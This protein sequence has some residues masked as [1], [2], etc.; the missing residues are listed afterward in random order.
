MHSFIVTPKSSGIS[1]RSDYRAVPK[2]GGLRLR[3]RGDQ[4][5]IELTFRPDGVSLQGDGFHHDLCVKGQQV[6]VTESKTGTREGAIK[7][8]QAPESG[9]RAAL[10]VAAGLIGVPVNLLLKEKPEKIYMHMT[11]RYDVMRRRG[12]TR[13]GGRYRVKELTQWLNGD[14]VFHGTGNRKLF[15]SVRDDYPLRKTTH[16]YTS[17]EHSHRSLWSI[18][19]A[20]AFGRLSGLT[21]PEQVRSGALSVWRE[22]GRPGTVGEALET[23]DQMLDTLYPF[24][25]DYNV[26]HLAEGSADTLQRL[27]HKE[28]GEAWKAIQAGSK[29]AL[30][31]SQAQ[32]K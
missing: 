31:R 9:L 11:G 3:H 23:A 19:K 10:G 32:Q 17:S 25:P 18:S 20:G 27:A 24:D 12:G 30:N 4:P 7:L 14:F 29:G 13:R 5:D 21:F 22:A 26:Y 6:T 16:F 15:G 8:A 1:T 28:P 2:E